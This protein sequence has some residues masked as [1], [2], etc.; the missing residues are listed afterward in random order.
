MY[1]TV[2]SFASGPC[3]DE[4][5]FTFAEMA[6]QNQSMQLVQIANLQKLSVVLKSHHRKETDVSL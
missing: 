2:T 1:V 3:D 6:S 4:S 5:D